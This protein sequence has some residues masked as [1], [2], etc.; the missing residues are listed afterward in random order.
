MRS[1]KRA[2]NIKPEQASGLSRL[3]V[4]LLGLWLTCVRGWRPGDH[5]HDHFTLVGS[6]EEPRFFSHVFSYVAFF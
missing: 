1:E 3:H 5:I 2:K 6:G 4:R